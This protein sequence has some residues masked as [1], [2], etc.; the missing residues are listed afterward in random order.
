MIEEELIKNK[1]WI[2][3]NLYPLFSP[4]GLIAEGSAEYGVGLAFENDE[5]GK[6]E[7]ETLYPLA[8]IDTENAGKLAQLNDLLRELKYSRIAIAKLYLDGEITRQ[9]AIKQTVKYSLVSTERAKSSVKFI[10]QYRAYVL[11]Y[12]IGEDLIAAYI[13]RN[14]KTHAERWAQFK[15]LLTQLSTAS[16]LIRDK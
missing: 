12:T 13:D 2:E 1:G 4:Y 8:G 3:F 10:E 6:F 11:N 5:K 9:E 16:D 15:Q 7:Q 14:S